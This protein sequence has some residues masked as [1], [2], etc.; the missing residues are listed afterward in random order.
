MRSVRGVNL[1]DGGCGGTMRT[2]DDENGL[3]VYSGE[4]VSYR[5]LLRNR[6]IIAWGRDLETR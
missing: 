5:S 6:S 2:W 4:L 1:R 3:H